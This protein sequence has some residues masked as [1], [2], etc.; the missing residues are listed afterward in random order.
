MSRIKLLSNSTINK[1]AAGEVIERPSS[2]VKELVENSIDACATEIT[3]T[4]ERSGKNLITVSDNGFGMNKEELLLCIQ[5]HSTS[6]LDEDNLENIENFGFRGEAI[7]SIAAISKFSITT[8][9][10]KDEHGYRLRVLAGEVYPIDIM[11]C[12]IGTKIEVRDIF[13]SVPARLKFLRTDKTELHSILSVIKKLALSN[14]MISFILIHNSKEILRLSSKA[15]R[16]KKDYTKDLDKIFKNRVRDVFGE[17]FLENSCFVSYEY[18]DLRIYGYTSLPTLNKS[19]SEDQFLFVNKRPIRD[20]LLSIALKLSYQDVIM[21]NKFPISIIFIDIDPKLVDVNVHPHKAEVKFFNPNQVKSNLIQA[22]KTT[23]S[24]NNRVSSTL[25]NKAQEYIK[26]NIEGE[27]N[28]ILETN[29]SK[30]ISFVK[31]KDTSTP[32]TLNIEEIKFSSK[33]QSGNKKTLD[34]EPKNL[35]NI[36]L[37]SNFYKDLMPIS[38]ESSEEGDTSSREKYK[39][40]RLGAAK[41]QIYDTYIISET[42][43]AL[44]IVDQH[45]S[46]ERIGYER[47]KEKIK[48]NGLITQNLLIPQKVELQDERMAE[49]IEENRENLETLSLYAKHIGNKTVEISAV[50]AILEQTNIKELVI[51]I[52]E[53]LLE[54]GD[55]F[56]LSKLI[57]NITETYACHYAIRAKKKLSYL[58]MNA[59]LREIE[60]NNFSAQCNHGRPTYIK[61]TKKDIEKLFGRR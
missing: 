36:E 59:L 14:P 9:T 39:K 50:P 58:E 3:V 61:L 37:T 38:R 31:E 45:A 54:I 52:A 6:K 4:L 5:R 49:L 16:E 10:Q 24:R 35:D 47:I 29:S 1:I 55:E 32:E 11:P 8:R 46:D 51:D 53:H 25:S 22:I 30:K 41:A 26:S 33:Y 40:Y 18:Q 13:F 44:I 12:N 42:E 17:S 27:E 34:L 48:N 43:D 60:N 2:V 21:N 56:V 57:E 23:L 7:P 20:K 19:S 15:I 28:L